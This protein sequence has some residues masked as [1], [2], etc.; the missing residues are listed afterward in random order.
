MEPLEAS[1]LYEAIRSNEAVA[2]KYSDGA[3]VVSFGMQMNLMEHLLWLCSSYS[4][5]F[6]I[7]TIGEAL[8][9]TS[10]L[11][12]LSLQISDFNI[13]DSG[14]TAIA[15]AL[16]MNSSLQTHLIDLT[17]NQIGA[18]GA[19]AIAEALMVNS[20][21]QKLDLAYCEIGDSGAAAIAKALKL[22]SSLQTLDLACCE[23]GDSAAV[24]FAKALKVNSVLQNLSLGNS[25]IGASGAA[26]LARTLCQHSPL[27]QL[28]LRKNSIGRAG[29][30]AIEQ[31]LERSFLGLE[32]NLKARSTEVLHEQ[33]T[34]K[35]RFL[36]ALSDVE[37]RSFILNDVPPALWPHALAKVTMFPSLIFHLLLQIPGS[38]SFW[39]SRSTGK[40]LTIDKN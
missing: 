26:A 29:V 31:S 38:S 3:I 20:S 17:S 14:A 36:Y 1:A 27:Q 34:R 39:C 37:F 15:E 30:K 21:L 23:I 32:Q 28:D 10:T 8:E 16:T 5:V 7:A 22:N 4:V 6:G 12:Q 19:A 40:R 18:A 11:Q 25:E 13:G 33:L 35:Y 2:V 9:V 24:T